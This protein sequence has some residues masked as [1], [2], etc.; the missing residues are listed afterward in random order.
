[1]PS[2]VFPMRARTGDRGRREA[3]VRASERTAPAWRPGPVD[4]VC[5]LYLDTDEP[6]AAVRR[7]L[8]A[9]LDRSV[10]EWRR[11][12]TIFWSA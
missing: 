10:S 7:T 12:V 11:D 6:L 5:E 9:V 1:M 8:S 3:I 4:D 2:V